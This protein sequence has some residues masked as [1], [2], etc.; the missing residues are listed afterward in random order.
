MNED[1]LDRFG[2]PFA[3]SGRVCRNL[4]VVLVDRRDD[5][6]SLHEIGARANDGQDL[7]AEIG[8]FDSMIAT[9]CPTTLLNTVRSTVSGLAGRVLR[10]ARIFSCTSRTLSISTRR[11]LLLR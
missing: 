2:R 7:H 8:A 1:V 9:I 3:P 6:R 5:R 11:P 4:L 10:T